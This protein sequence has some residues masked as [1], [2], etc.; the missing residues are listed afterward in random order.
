MPVLQTHTRTTPATATPLRAPAPPLPPLWGVRRLVLANVAVV[1]VAAAFLVVYRF[2]AALFLL[3]MGIALGMAVKPGVEWLRRR[4]L[5]RWAG[6]LLIYLG[7]GAAAAGVLLLAVPV[8]AQEIEALISRGPR[9]VEH[10]RVQLL[11]SSSSTLRR[12]A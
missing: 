12:L 5:P 7:L 10:L 2:A 1:A 9:Q 6:A 4:G 3:F 8:V 11:W